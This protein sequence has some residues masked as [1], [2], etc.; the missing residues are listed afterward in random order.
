[1]F[2]TRLNCWQVHP[3][4]VP[5]GLHFPRPPPTAP[6]GFEQGRSSSE[7][8]KLTV[9]TTSS[10]SNLRQCGQDGA[11]T[12]ADPRGMVASGTLDSGSVDAQREAEE[13]EALKLLRGWSPAPGA[14]EPPTPAR[15]QRG[16]SR[17]PGGL[18]ERDR[19]DPSARH[20]ASSGDSDIRGRLRA[21]AEC[22]RQRHPRRSRSPKREK[23]GGWAGAYFL[24]ISG[25]KQNY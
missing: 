3:D 24:E 22:L 6:P 14:S 11:C 19:S 21:A 5:G 20:S 12:G 17:I 4:G 15:S 8:Y 16:R 2:S 7:R 9:G 25:Q 23:A 13:W 10:S 18:Y 1:M